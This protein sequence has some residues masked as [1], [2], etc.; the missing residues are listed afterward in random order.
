MSAFGLPAGT[1]LHK[2][3]GTG[4]SFVVLD[5][6]NDLIDVDASSVA[7]LCSPHTGIGADGLIRCVFTDGTWFMDYRNADGSLAEMCGNGIRAFVDHLRLVTLVT[8]EVGETLPVMTRAGLRAVTVIDAPRGAGGSGQQW[9]SVDMGPAL[10]STAADMS[11]SVVGLPGTF[12]A[13]RVAMP[14]PHA[15]IDVGTIGRLEQV[16][17]PDVD[18]LDAP[19]AIRPTYEPWPEAGVNLE[20]I[21]D[22]TE[23]GADHGTLHMRVLE[24][25]VGE[26]QSCGTGCCAAAVAAAIR[27]GSGAPRRWFVNVPGGRVC[28]DLIDEVGAGAGQVDGSPS[29]AGAGGVVLSGPAAHIA[30]FSVD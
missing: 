18:V 11:V 12:D 27:W 25:G 28:V 17:L 21:V 29:F 6:P 15:V 26:T 23:P 4:N 3:H 19:E 20:V 22:A 10:T 13:L 5:D 16:I 1:T 24:R 30:T 8:L 9:Y 2:A 14:N 7:Q